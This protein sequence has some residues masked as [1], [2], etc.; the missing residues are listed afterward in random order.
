MIPPHILTVRTAFEAA[1][2]QWPD[3]PFL[4]VLPE[5]ADVYGIEAGEI[6]YGAA[7]EKV[8]ALTSSYS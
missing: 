7:Q 2:S 4:N 6:T 8:A 3:R 5:T 1:A